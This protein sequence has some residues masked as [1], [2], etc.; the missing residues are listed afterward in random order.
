MTKITLDD[1][2]NLQNEPTAVGVINA[3]SAV[4]ETAF[5]NTLS[6]DGTT[7]NHM[8]T[9]LDMNSNR[10]INLGAPVND[11]DA[12]RYSDLQETVFDVGA[13]VITA[14]GQSLIDDPTASDAQTTLGITP[15]V[16]TILDDAD[17]TAVKATIGVATDIS[18]ATPP[19]VIYP[20]A[21]L[22]EPSGF[23][24][25]YGQ[26]ISRTTYSALFTVLSTTYGAGDGS[27][28][29]NLPDL[30]GRVIA[31]QDD[32]GGVSANR[33]TGISG[34]LDGD[35]L[36][37][38]GGG[39]SVTLTTANLPPYTPAGTIAHSGQLT[40][41][42]YPLVGN[43]TSAALG[44]NTINGTTTKQINYASFVS[45]FTGT[46]QGGTSTAFSKVQPTIILNY[47]IKT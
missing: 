21:G 26:A 25:C 4:I 1:V 46:A 16:K 5:D 41:D 30:R 2:V 34:S 11:N 33:L 23:L 35:T 10:I 27:T 38:A 28:T 42:L 40:A 13:T 24:F 39:E 3:N 20:Y 6:R 47:I 29:F 45:T 9:S 37:T 17:A 14:F 31:G 22:T 18:A 44:Q 19:G 15:Y 32:M 36:G 43:T 12:V 8:N 7:P